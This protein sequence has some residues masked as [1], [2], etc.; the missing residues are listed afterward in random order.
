MN[1]SYGTRSLREIARILFRHWFLLVLIVAIGGAGTWVVC[2]YFAPRHYR[3]SIDIIFKRP[4]NKNP[5]ATDSGERMLEVFVKAQ[6]Q[7]VLSDVVVAR[8]KVLSEDPALRRQ[9]L[10]LQKEWDLTA[11]AG[12]P[13]GAAPQQKIVEFLTDR[14]KSPVP[15]KVDDLLNNH[16]SEFNKFRNSIKLETPGGEQVA[17]TE[18]FTISVDRP[19]PRNVADSYL[20]AQYAAEI[21]ADMYIFRYQ[22]IQQQLNSPAATVMSDVV[23]EFRSDLDRRMQAYQDFI[24][25]NP[26]D[27][28]VLEQ[29]LKSGT[30]HGVQVVLSKIR[31]GD[32]ALFLQLARDKAMY[33]VL[34]K[35]L[36]AIALQPGGLEQMSNAQVAEAVAGAPTDFFKDD[37]AYVEQIKNIATLHTR[38]ARIETQFMEESRDMK[39]IHAQ[40]ARANRQLLGAIVA[41]TKGLAASVAAREEQK[42]MNAALIQKTADEQKAI[43]A[44]LA[45]YA[46]LK[47]DFEV[48][49]KQ[50][51]RL[52]QDQIDANAAKLIAHEAIT[53]GKLNAA[54][55][56]DPRKPVV[57]L[58][59]IYTAVAVAV[60]LLLALAL[61]FLA[62]H[63]DHTLRSTLE[64]ER[65]LGLPVLA[66]V[67]KRG[68]GLIV[69]G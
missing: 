26:A 38:A 28:G 44:K 17:M 18:T 65:Y 1:D 3:S 16:Q 41:F 9:W 39:Y 55:T 5:L 68:R 36:P 14:R 27:I 63:Y 21:L 50:L 40:L 37:V 20:N 19:G 57:P 49:Q 58:T 62:D 7:I 29:L 23:N 15:E 24:Q 4:Q 35:S 45:Q 48:A 12:Q 69:S 46:R 67:K 53:I 30:E 54:S 25:K 51:E 6:Q 56:P 2:E 31:E 13:G 64:A 8:A 32:A 43:H 60:S 66:S 61:V 22:Q 34:Q 47:N 42:T 59:G 33:N 10:A 11:R 52:E